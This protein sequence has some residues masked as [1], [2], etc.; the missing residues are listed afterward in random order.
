MACVFLK[1]DKA[2]KRSDYRSRSANIHSNEQVGI[3][4]REL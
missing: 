1:C 4:L 3:V 2:G